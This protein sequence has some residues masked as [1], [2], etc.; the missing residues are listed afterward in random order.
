L[1]IV[2]VPGLLTLPGAPRADELATDVEVRVV[3]TAEAELGKIE[4]ALRA[5]PGVAAGAVQNITLPLQTA[6]EE[7][8]GKGPVKLYPRA[9]YDACLAKLKRGESRDAVAKE[10]VDLHRRGELAKAAAGGDSAGPKKVA[11]FVFDR[12][13]LRYP[14]PHLPS[15]IRGS[16]GEKMKGIYQICVGTDGKVT[17]VTTVQSIAG[18]DQAVAEQLQST[19]VYKPQPAPVC[20]QRAFIFTFN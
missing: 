10:L 12:E 11:S 6:I 14:D 1:R 2:L 5:Q 18:A 8:L 15:N 19:W 7:D 17:K 20:T 16:P 9:L 4:K 3:K 13:R